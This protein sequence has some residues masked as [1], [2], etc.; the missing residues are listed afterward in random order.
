[1][2]YFDMRLR[3][4][5]L[6]ATASRITLGRH[7]LA[8]HSLRFREHIVA[9]LRRGDGNR[10]RPHDARRGTIDFQHAVAFFNDV[11]HGTRSDAAGN[12]KLKRAVTVGQR[13]GIVD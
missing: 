1:M 7:G 4:M 11:R 9:R 13:A 2:L 3:M 12:R 6:S 5:R 10:N 8:Q